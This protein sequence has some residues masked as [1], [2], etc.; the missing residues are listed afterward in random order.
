MESGY[1][2]TWNDNFGI[3][4]DDHIC[5]IRTSYNPEERTARF[6]A[7]VMLLED[8]WR[9]TDFALLQKCYPVSEVL[10]TL[11][12]AG[13]NVIESYA[14]DERQGLIGLTEEADRAYFLCRKPATASAD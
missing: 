5:I 8:G 13:F 2:L 7:T 4:E 9:R 1:S 3:V 12:A 14:L 6:D 11:G 10:S